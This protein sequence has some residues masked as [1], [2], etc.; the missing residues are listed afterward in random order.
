MRVTTAHYVI[1]LEFGVHVELIES[2][3]EDLTRGQQPAPVVFLIPGNCVQL[4]N[5]V[6]V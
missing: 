5:V 6:N 1:V 3:Q 2:F 4:F